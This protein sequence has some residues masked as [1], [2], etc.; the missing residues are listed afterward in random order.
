[1]TDFRQKIIN[2]SENFG[3]QGLIWV[4]ILLVMVMLA[5]SVLYFGTGDPALSNNTAS[6]N[7]A[8]GSQVVQRS[9]RLYSVFYNREIFSPTNL[10]IQRGDT[11]KFINESRDALWVISGP[12]PDHSGWLDFDS[13]KD[14]PFQEFY[15]ITFNS[16]GIYSYHNEKNINETGTIIVR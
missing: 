3:G 14:I 6:N 12:H 10:R 8:N 11:V 16:P 5:L 1:M 2:S 7:T 4:F 15:S 9:A 13:R